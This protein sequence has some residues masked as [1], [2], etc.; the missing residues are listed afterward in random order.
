MR[1]KRTSVLVLLVVLLIPTVAHADNRLHHTGKYVRH[2]GLLG[3][4]ID[5]QYTTDHDFDF[6]GNKLY[7]FNFSGDYCPSKLQSDGTPLPPGY[8]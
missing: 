4:S 8:G 1:I 3:G 7:W 5:C 6:F 2:W